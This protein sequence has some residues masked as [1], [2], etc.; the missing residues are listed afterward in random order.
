VGYFGFAKDEETRA[1][2]LKEL[3]K[4]SEQTGATRAKLAKE[5]SSKK[6]V[7]SERLKKIR[8]KQRAKRGLPPEEEKSEEEEVEDEDDK[9]TNEEKKDSGEEEG[10]KEMRPWDFGKSGVFGPRP[11]SFDELDEKWLKDRRSDRVQEFAPPSNLY[12]QGGLKRA[13]YGSSSSTKPSATAT[14]TTSTSSNNP[15]SNFVR[16]ESNKDDDSY[17]PSSSPPPSTIPGSFKAPSQFWKKTPASSTVTSSQGGYQQQKPVPIVDE[18]AAPV[19]AGTSFLP[20]GNN[21][22]GTSGTGS[23]RGRGTEIAPPP[24]FDYYHGQTTGKPVKRSGPGIKEEI[25]AQAVSSG[26]RTLRE[27]FEAQERK[28]KQKMSEEDDKDDIK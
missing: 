24:T 27:K 2:Q 10:R 11:S 12:S 19:A 17:S 26:L 4:L 22:S 16:G 13:Y 9:E 7:L 21:K 8:A 25:M 15:Y 14:S 18:C 28:K 6:A 23:E 5:K 1:E 3:R 20:R